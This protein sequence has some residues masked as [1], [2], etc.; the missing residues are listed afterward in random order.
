MAEVII[1]G[2][3]LKAYL[4]EAPQAYK[5]IEQVIDTLTEIGFS[6]KVARL[7]PLAVLKGDG[8]G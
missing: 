8:G 5:D 7:R 4:D 2:D 6:Q 1:S 3:N